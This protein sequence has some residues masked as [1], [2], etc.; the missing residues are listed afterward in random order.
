VLQVDLADFRDL[1]N[2]ILDDLDERVFGVHWCAPHPATSRRIL[3][4]DH[5][6]ACVRSVERQSN[7]RVRWLRL[8]GCAVEL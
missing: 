5:L 8:G 2:E 6:F 4:S 7:G 3:I 1:G